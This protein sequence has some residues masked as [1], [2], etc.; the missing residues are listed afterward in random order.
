MYSDFTPIFPAESSSLPIA[1]ITGASRGIGAALTEA[2]G[3]RPWY[4]G[5]VFPRAAAFM[6]KVWG[7]TNHF[8]Y[9]IA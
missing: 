2:P 8:A 3:V 9:S 4:T 7:K 1:L 5:T 6:R